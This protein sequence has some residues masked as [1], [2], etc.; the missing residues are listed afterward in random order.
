MNFKSKTVSRI[1]LVSALGLATVSSFFAQNERV[2]AAIILYLSKTFIR[3]SNKKRVQTDL[4]GSTKSCFEK[5]VKDRDEKPAVVL[6]E[7]V[8]D[9]FK[10]KGLKS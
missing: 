10:I 5:I 9:Y 8:N 2:L 6:R 7:I 4:K 1:V 3:M